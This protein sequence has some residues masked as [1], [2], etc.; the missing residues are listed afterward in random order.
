M[1]DFI[2]A[3]PLWA[4]ALL[5]NAWFDGFRPRRYMGLQALGVTAAEHRQRRRFVL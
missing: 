1:I 5:L 3:L 2:F 4:L